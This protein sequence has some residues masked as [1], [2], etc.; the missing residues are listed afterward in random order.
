MI[1]SPEG[2]YI[3][4]A[5]SSQVHPSVLTA[6][7][8]DAIKTL[9]DRSGMRK[10]YNA[11]ANYKYTVNVSAVWRN[12]SWYRA[13]MN[14]SNATMFASQAVGSAYGLLHCAFDCWKCLYFPNFQCSHESWPWLHNVNAGTISM[15]SELIS[16]GVERFGAL[17][18]ILNSNMLFKN[19]R[20]N[21]LLVWD[22]MS[23]ALERPAAFCDSHTQD[24]A[25]WTVLVFNRSLPLINTCMYLSKNKLHASRN[26]GHYP[27]CAHNIKNTN[28]FLGALGK[29][30]YE[31]VNAHE[32]DSIIPTDK[33]ELQC[34]ISNFTRMH[35][36]SASDRSCEH[37]FQNARVL[38]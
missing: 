24:Q 16:I 15:Y 35:W 9:N 31:V 4:W 25:A 11:A 18:N 37:I 3:H 29:G 34:P 8:Q 30:V 26:D 1:Q 33:S 10:A 12:A 2:H 22:W 32:Y 38:D 23:M 20:E 17:P 21:R 14:S 13:H 7:V 28:L 5:D 36:P 6:N 27:W 19:T